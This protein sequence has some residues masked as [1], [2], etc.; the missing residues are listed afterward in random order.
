V[1]AGELIRLAAESRD[2]HYVGA[3]YVPPSVKP[4]E[5]AIGTPLIEVLKKPGTAAPHT[6][7]GLFLG[8]QL[9][10]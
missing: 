1:V 4:P 7:A 3:R 2:I 5:H 8:E 9:G 10:L 6:D